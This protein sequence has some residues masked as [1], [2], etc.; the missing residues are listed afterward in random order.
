MKTINVIRLADVNVSVLVMDDQATSGSV[1][2]RSNETN[3][4]MSA[5]TVFDTKSLTECARNGVLDRTLYLQSYNSENALSPDERLQVRELI[6]A[7][8]A[9][10]AW[11]E[12]GL[13]ELFETESYVEGGMRLEHRNGELIKSEIIIRCPAIE[14]DVSAT[15][16]F[17]NGPVNFTTTLMNNPTFFEGIS[18]AVMYNLSH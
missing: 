3:D 17:S 5:V 12:D 4:I 7:G 13:F 2:V 1:V 10:A 9:G 8:N 18:A 11:I 15:L 16:D 14:V 6:R